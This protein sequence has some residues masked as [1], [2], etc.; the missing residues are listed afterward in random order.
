MRVVMTF[1]P[2]VVNELLVMAMTAAAAVAVV[3]VGVAAVMWMMVADMIVEM[4]LWWAMETH[5]DD[6]DDG[7]VDGS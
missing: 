7:A 6:D 4:Q 1:C 2:V 5:A 3:A